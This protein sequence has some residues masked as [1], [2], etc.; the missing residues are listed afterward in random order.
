MRMTAKEFATKN[1]MP[2]ATVKRYCKK[3]I[4]RCHRIGRKYSIDVTYALKALADLDEQQAMLSKPIKPIPRRQSRR[5]NTPDDF[6][7]ALD[8]MR[9]GIA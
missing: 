7:K 5:I 3:G 8:D 4:F 9:R 1:N 2:L 6:L